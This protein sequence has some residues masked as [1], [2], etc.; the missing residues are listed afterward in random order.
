MSRADW[1][2]ALG[3]FAAVAVPAAGLHYTAPADRLDAGLTAAPFGWP[4]L[5][6]AHLAAALPLGLLAGVMLRGALA[7]S[8]SVAWVG[9][10]FAATGL[11]TQAL[12]AAGALLADGSP[13]EMPAL[14][15]RVAVALALVF[16]W[17]V[18]ALGEP[19]RFAPPGRQGVAFALAV[20]AALVPC[21][22][23]SDTLIEAKTRQAAELLERERV[24]R[25]ATVVTGLC[26]LGSEYPI[27]KRPPGEIRDALS[28][29]IPEL[30][31]AAD[32]P[33]RAD[34]PP[35]A[36]L[37]RAVLLVR[38]ERLDAAAELLQPLAAADPTATMLL[39]AV[40]RDQG[41]YAAS[42]KLFADIA[43]RT[44]PWVGKDPQALGYFK[45]ALESLVFNA[46]ADYRPADALRWLEYGRDALP[47]EAAFYDYQLGLHYQSAGRPH[48]AIEFLESAARRDPA[49][50]GRVAG[51]LRELRTHTPGC[52]LGG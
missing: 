35:A 2:L 50:A 51:P 26:E 29:A 52:F 38:V 28:G 31:R 48:R 1:Q 27:S 37:N 45:T 9:A 7:D 34:A 16:P 3:L 4:R 6:V 24:V 21:G 25:A 14:L 40:Y 32:R 46:R 22:L 39:A 15:A 30:L 8:V 11:A 18:A 33:L 23:Y 10:G 20:A 12:P 36:R 49:F 43:A 47:G 44:R 41:R 42:D 17:C 19:S 5:L 13:G